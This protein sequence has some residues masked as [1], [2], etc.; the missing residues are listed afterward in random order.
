MKKWP[1]PGGTLVRE[2]VDFSGYFC[3]PPHGAFDRYLE[4]YTQ[5][6]H[7]KGGDRTSAAGSPS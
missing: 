5:A 4:L 6:A 1:R 2:D 7:R 3:H